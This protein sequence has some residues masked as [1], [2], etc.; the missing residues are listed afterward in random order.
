MVRHALHLVAPQILTLP[1]SRVP[2]LVN[3]VSRAQ[4]LG[5][6]NIYEGAASCRR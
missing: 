1:M 3:V 2:L 4:V 5:L 6:P